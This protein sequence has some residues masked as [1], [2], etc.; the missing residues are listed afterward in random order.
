MSFASEQDLLLP[1]FG[2]LVLDAQACFK[3]ALTAMSRPGSV[4]NLPV[5]VPSPAPLDTGTTALC[6]TL[7]DADT[8]LW[9]APSAD[10]AAVRAYLRFHCGCPIVSQPAL[11]DFVILMGAADP[12]SIDAFNCGEEQYPDQST[13]IIWQLE[14][15]GGGA[16]ATLSGPGVN[17]S[18]AVSPL[19]LPSDFSAQW[20][21]NRALYPQGVDLFMT[22]GAQ[23][24][25]LPRSVEWE[26]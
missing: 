19:G 5:S 23:I 22:A 25:G 13:T 24:L 3:A 16:R 14:A 26:G 17:G 1:G 12:M 9:L 2:N 6:L 18:V 21:V 10:S 20:A 15:L 8:R 7:L 4:Q 11:A